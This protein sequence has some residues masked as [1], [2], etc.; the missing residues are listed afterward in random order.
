M[1]EADE[2]WWTEC[3]GGGRWRLRVLSLRL[4]RSEE[5]REKKEENEE[6]AKYGIRCDFVVER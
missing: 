4:E 5:K 2:V 1:L 6:S 3:T